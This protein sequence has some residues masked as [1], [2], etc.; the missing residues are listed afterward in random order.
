MR[1]FDSDKSSKEV[2]NRERVLLGGLFL[3]LMVCSILELLD[4]G[5]LLV[6]RLLVGCLLVRFRTPG[7]K[8]F[9]ENKNNMNYG[10]LTLSSWHAAAYAGD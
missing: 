6:G 1:Q 8:E 3:G 10:M 9:E 4:V 5:H 2:P 7:S